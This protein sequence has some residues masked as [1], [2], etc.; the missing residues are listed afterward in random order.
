MKIVGI[1]A[2]YNPFH[3]GHAYQIQTAKE[4]T[5]ADYVIVVMSGNYVQRGTPAILD[6]FS[7]ASMAL[8]NGADLVFELPVL[9]AT[10]SAES[11]AMAGITLL[12]QLG[13]VDFVSFGSE[14]K[15]I[16][17]LNTIAQILTDE[18][19]DFSDFLASALKQGH[20]FPSARE[21]AL[22][23]YMNKHTNINISAEHLHDVISSP[24][25]ILAIEYCKALYTRHSSIQPCPILR[26]GSS[27]HEA[28]LQNTFSSASALRKLLFSNNTTSVKKELLQKNM[29]A[30]ALSQVWNA[31][32]AFMDIN[33]FSSMIFYKLFSEQQQGFASY[34]DCSIFLSNRICNHLDSYLNYES[35]CAKIKTK[36]ITYTRIQRVLLHI[37]LNIQENNY[38]LGKKLGYIPWLRLLGFHKSASFLLKEIQTNSALPLIT[39][40]AK[41]GD[42]L[43]ADAASLYQIDLRASNLYYSTLAQKT[44]TYKKNELERQLIRL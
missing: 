42:L 18:P 44:K 29:P 23:S 32:D 1:I 35:F 28:T 20:N 17:L 41:S 38:I 43:S 36:E 31:Q 39:K 30:D 6:K 19:K 3:N 25:N 7:R 14:T 34:A 37:L 11:F 10:A 27:Y 16:A 13:I 24:N 12:D 4:L 21:Y 2:E 33:D 26:V 9:W 40:P 8:H 15:D 22:F 5:G